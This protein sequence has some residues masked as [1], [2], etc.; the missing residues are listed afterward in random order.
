M[1]NL[2]L[3]N[4]G[5]SQMKPQEMKATDGGGIIGKVAKYLWKNRKAIAGFIAGEAVGEAIDAA[6]GDCCCCCCC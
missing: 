1:N 6:S 2:C 4:Y 3:E 5:V